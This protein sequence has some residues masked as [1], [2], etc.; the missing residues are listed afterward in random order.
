MLYTPRRA[1]F[2][3]CTAP[4]KEST[5]YNA[6]VGIML[7]IRCNTLNGIHPCTFLCDHSICTQSHAAASAVTALENELHTLYVAATHRP[8]SEQPDMPS[9]AAALQRRVRALVAEEEG[10][11]DEIRKLKVRHVW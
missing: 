8:A 5:T 4:H 1:G 9:L 11:A 10:A 2:P 6:L 3:T 7:G